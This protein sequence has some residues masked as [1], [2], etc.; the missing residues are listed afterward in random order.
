MPHPPQAQLTPVFAALGDP[1][2]LAIIRRLCD[3]GPQPTIRLT[4]AT[5]LTRQGIAKHLRTLEQAGL[6]RADRVGRDRIWELRRER[7]G[8]IR[9][10]LDEISTQ[11]DN[12]IARLRAALEK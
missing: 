6:V 8:E 10:Y 7:L 9:K 2:R 4:A 11:W 5:A 12:A 3:S 1:T